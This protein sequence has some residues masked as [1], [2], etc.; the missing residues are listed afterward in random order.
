MQL[1]VRSVVEIFSALAFDERRFDGLCGVAAVAQFL[2]E[3]RSG[4]APA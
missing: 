1:R 3:L 2:R 4:H